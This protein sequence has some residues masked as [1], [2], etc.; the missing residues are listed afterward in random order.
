MMTR[1]LD[2][3]SAGT[4]TKIFSKASAYG[5]KCIASEV[6]NHRIEPATEPETWHLEYL[7]GRWVLASYGVPQI[8]F[9]YEEVLKFLDR[10]APQ[11]TACK[12]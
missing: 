12:E 8:H 6:G 4:P 11:E 5:L 3:C 2:V 9:R 1:H 10:F 7:H